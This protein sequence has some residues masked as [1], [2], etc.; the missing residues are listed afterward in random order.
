MTKIRVKLTTIKESQTSRK[1]Q[2]NK[3]KPKKKKLMRICLAS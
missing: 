1:V 2:K 3:M